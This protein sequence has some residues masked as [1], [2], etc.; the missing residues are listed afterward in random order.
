MLRLIFHRF[1]ITSFQFS[2]YFI[3][4]AIRHFQSEY[5]CMHCIWTWFKEKF[6]FYRHVTASLNVFTILLYPFRWKLSGFT[7]RKALHNYDHRRWLFTPMIYLLAK[8][9]GGRVFFFENHLFICVGGWEFF[10]FESHCP[11]HSPGD[12]YLNGR[13]AV[14][15]FL[16]TPLPTVPG[17]VAVIAKCSSGIHFNR[18]RPPSL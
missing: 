9:I 3:F 18:R 10:F 16:N 5:V 11:F 4:L 2:I 6:Y 15:I 13:I 12:K 7:T 17:P 8:S 1:I 14:A